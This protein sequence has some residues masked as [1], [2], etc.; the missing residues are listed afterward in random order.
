MNS[1][2]P[3]TGH[4]HHQHVFHRL[5]WLCRSKVGRQASVRLGA[6]LSGQGLLH[7]VDESSGRV[8]ATPGVDVSTCCPRTRC[9]TRVQAP[10]FLGRP[11]GRQSALQ[12]REEGAGAGRPDSVNVV[13][14]HPVPGQTKPVEAQHMHIRRIVKETSAAPVVCAP[15]NLG[16]PWGPI[17]EAQ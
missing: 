11:G 14:V 5:L 4:R 3:S 12:D 15:G 8:A 7:P 2:N 16:H 6:Q 13:P 17:T 9:P 1:R 10:F